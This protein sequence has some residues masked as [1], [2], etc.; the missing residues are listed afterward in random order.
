MMMTE[1][2]IVKPVGELEIT[3]WWRTNQIDHLPPSDLQMLI[4][5][6]MMM[7]MMMTH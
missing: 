7:M 5:M 3:M 1:N 4:M 6:M 2:Q